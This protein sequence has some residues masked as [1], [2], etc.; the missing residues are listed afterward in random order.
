MG[1][2]AGGERW[3]DGWYC[4]DM[5]IWNELDRRGWVSKGF[6]VEVKDRKNAPTTSI[7]RFQDRW[8]AV[9]RNLKAPWR[10]QFY[11][12]VGSDYSKHLLQY[13]K[14]SETM[15]WHPWSL[16][17]R[18]ERFQRY[19]EGMLDGR[20]RIEKLRMYLSFPIMTHSVG[21]LT[22]AGMKR[23][24]T[25]ILKGLAA[26]FESKQIELMNVLG[27]EAKIKPMDTVAHHR[28]HLEHFNKSLERRIDFDA[29]PLLNT[30][31]S[32]FECLRSGIM[33]NP[34]K[35]PMSDWGHFCDGYYH[36]FIVL[37]EHPSD[38]DEFTMSGLLDLGFLEYAVIVNVR[39]KDFKKEV[40]RED[41][42]IKRLSDDAEGEGKFSYSEDVA[43]KQ[44][45]VK[46][47]KSG[48]KNPMEFDFVVHVWDAERD[49]LA[50]KTGA[51][52]AAI[53][54]MS[55]ANFWDL[56]LPTTCKN[57]FF[58]TIPG[59]AFG[60]YDDYG[61]YIDN[62]TLVD[63]LP[64]SSSFNGDLDGAHALYEGD[65]GNLVG[66]QLF[67]NGVTQNAICTG[68][69]RAGKSS[70]LVDLLSQVEAYFKY[71]FILDDGNS[72]GAFTYVMGHKPIIFSNNAQ[73]TLN[74]LDTHGLPLTNSHVNFASVF[75]NQMC[76]ETPDPERRA[77]R[78]AQISYYINRVYTDYY[79]GW[80][81]KNTELIPVIARYSICLE[82]YISTLPAGVDIL[83]AWT[84]VRD[85]LAA[86]DDKW[87]G[88]YEK[89]S[90]GEV[91]HAMADDRLSSLI[92][93]LAYAWFTPADMPRHSLLREFM[94]AETS[95]DHKKEEVQHTA[96]LLGDWD[97][98]QGRHGRLFD[99]VGDVNLSERITQ[100]E[101]G[102]LGEGADDIK[103]LIT[104]AV[105]CQVRSHIM[106]M[107]RGWW[108]LVNLEEAGRFGMIPGASRLISEFYAQ[109][110]KYSTWIMSILQQFAQI[111]DE[112]LKKILTDNSKEFFF[113][114]MPKGEDVKDLRRYVELSDLSAAR[115][116]SYPSPEF[117]PP[118]N[119]HSSV[120]YYHRGVGDPVCGT[121]RNYVS[122]EMLY[123]SSTQGALFDERMKAMKIE[124]AAGGD[125]LEMV[126]REA[127]KK[128]VG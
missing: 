32:I 14:A 100:I 57:M 11:W 56:E 36:N 120:M 80:A 16:D 19:W 71:L 59:W 13:K 106:N 128:F 75:A 121:I 53:H 95:S 105:T 3:C 89:I 87:L 88:I 64:L 5:I 98:E 35:N 1:I 93:D 52:K 125:M 55:G 73:M 22:R 82:K 37:S 42:E 107:P 62:E 116:D 58:H 65:N 126:R 50:R 69:T 122:P 33:G 102:P 104:F 90:E 117:L 40:E 70:L 48:R 119:R 86:K 24:Q 74:Y 34:E 83:E 96:A 72:Y 109:L 78:L 46:S 103:A 28:H 63:L 31:K 118:E 44:E 26:Q 17:Q 113:L 30:E 97:A 39:P 51:V 67:Q 43:A 81:S 112:K 77:I 21:R 25:E 76:G 49:G 108:K 115:L 66:V 94:M 54:L 15:E 27:G 68:A 101:L 10:A 38:L 110:P 9:L 6:E 2:F 12:T 18:D 79:K 8:S 23:H 41:Q 84:D 123:V 4:R 111:G 85:L 60:T 61:L 124:A 92:K 114:R 7:D 29:K 47:L 99:G 20:L 91:S 127:A 45:K